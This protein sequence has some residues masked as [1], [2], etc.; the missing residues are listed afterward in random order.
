[1]DKLYALNFTIKVNP[2][3]NIFKSGF[4]ANNAP[5]SGEMIISSKIFYDFDLC[6]KSLTTLMGE[7]GNHELLAGGEN[8]AVVSKINPLI[9]SSEKSVEDTDEWDKLTLAKMFLADSVALKESVLKYSIVGYITVNAAHM[10]SISKD[11]T[12]TLQ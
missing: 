6:K 7:L 3:A 10:Q 4:F 12:E 1:M 11:S 9:D 8:L 2:S 5:H